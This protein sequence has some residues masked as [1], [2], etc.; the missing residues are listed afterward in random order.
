MSG[1]IVLVVKVL[2]QRLLRNALSREVF[3]I[4]TFKDNMILQAITARKN[5]SLAT[6][7]V[8]LNRPKLSGLG[9]KT[10]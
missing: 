4:Q 6:E 8:M 3:T 1:N 7:G 5:E 9:L 2:K 10:W